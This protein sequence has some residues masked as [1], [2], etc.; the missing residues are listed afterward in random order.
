MVAAAVKEVVGAADKGRITVDRDAADAAAKGARADKGEIDHI[1]TMTMVEIRPTHHANLVLACSRCIPMGTV[2]S[3]A[4]R[5]ITPENV[6][7]PLFRAQ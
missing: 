3:V 1:P 4:R 5:T 6:Q 7:M 2:F